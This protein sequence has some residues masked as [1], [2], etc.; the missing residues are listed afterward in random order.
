MRYLL[1]LLL[2][3]CASPPGAAVALDHDEVAMRPSAECERDFDECRRSGDTCPA[4]GIA[5]YCECAV[6]I[7]E[8]CSWE[9]R[10][11]VCCEYLPPTLPPHI[12]EVRTWT[13]E[14]SALQPFATRGLSANWAW[15]Q[16]PAYY[17]L[18]Q[19]GN[20]GVPVVH[21]WLDPPHGAHMGAAI[22]R[23]EGAAGHTQPF[24]RPALT[25]A[26]IDHAGTPAPLGF[27]SDTSSGYEYPHD[28]DVALDHVADRENCT[29]AAEFV[30]ESDYP[31]S[32]GFIPGGRLLSLRLKYQ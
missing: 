31:S 13:P 22:A 23:W 10:H 25:I 2:I 27:A 17:A 8:H 15:G 28:I 3:G 30:G 4:H 29:Y 5:Y 32:T 16:P 20:A 24:K 1:P 6:D 11:L 9:D 14:P 19:Q 7:P 18:E 12:P 21:M 26:C